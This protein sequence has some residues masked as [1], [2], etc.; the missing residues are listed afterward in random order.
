MEQN[1]L[2]ALDIER[3]KAF[4]TC[5]DMW[6]AYA[7]DSG[8]LRGILPDFDYLKKSLPRV[9]QHQGLSAIQL[10]SCKE[11]KH[12]L[13]TWIF[14]YMDSKNVLSVFT[15]FRE[16]VKPTR[17]GN[18]V[19]EAGS[20]IPM[21]EDVPALLA[22]KIYKHLKRHFSFKN[23]SDVLLDAL[24]LD[25]NLFILEKAHALPGIVEPETLVSMQWVYP[26]GTLTTKI[27]RGKGQSIFKASSKGLNW[28]GILKT[29]NIPGRDILDER[30]QRAILR[31]T[32]SYTR[33]LE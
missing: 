21:Y 4:K 23:N 29:F 11:S 14:F 33:V 13:R 6:F 2:N 9:I 7:K 1:A 30:V 25:R 32:L 3:E 28:P 22:E 10:K 15:S 18:K 8:G 16:D 17:A 26:I 5:M 24:C 19:Y 12:R 20:L 31:R 27:P